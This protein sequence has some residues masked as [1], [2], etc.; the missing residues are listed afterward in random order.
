MSVPVV[1]R[2][3]CRDKELFISQASSKKSNRSLGNSEDKV[4]VI[5]VTWENIISS[6]APRNT[7]GQQGRL[8]SEQ[9]KGQEA[10]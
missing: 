7:N 5:V 8:A 4:R 2:V 3:E 1:S 10:R 6:Q 9:A